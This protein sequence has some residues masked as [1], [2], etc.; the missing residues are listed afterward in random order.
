MNN[1][2]ITYETKDNTYIYGKIAKTS[3]EQQQE[4]KEHIRYM[5]LQKFIGIIATIISITMVIYG[6]APALLLT[7]V[8]IAVTLTNDKV[9][10]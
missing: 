7:I 3:Y 8:G 10:G 4:R 9:I 5:I 1:Q 6:I 2:I